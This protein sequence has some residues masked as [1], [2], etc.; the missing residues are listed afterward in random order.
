MVQA[1]IEANEGKM[2]AK[3]EELA[4]AFMFFI[5]HISRKSII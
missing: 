3:G 1:D 2:T 5:T 4:N